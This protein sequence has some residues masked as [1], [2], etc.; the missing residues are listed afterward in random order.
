MIKHT[1]DKQIFVTYKKRSI[2][3]FEFL[4]SKDI[5]EKFGE[6]PF[7]QK[8]EVINVLQFGFT[9]LTNTFRNY[10]LSIDDYAF[11]LFLFYNHESSIALYLRTLGQN[12][13]DLEKAEGIKEDD[14]ALNRRVLRLALEQ[15][16]DINYT[17]DPDVTPAKARECLLKLED[18]LYLGAEIYYFADCIAEN[19]MI[20]NA[21]SLT[22]NQYGRLNIQRNHHNE[23][24]FQAIRGV[25][26]TGF[27]EGIVSVE[28]VNELRTTL[29]KCMAI[30]YDFAGGIIF[31]IKKHHN[32]KDK[33]QTVQPT[34]L[35]QNLAA[36]GVSEVDASNFYSGLSLSRHNKLP[37]ADSVYK[38]NSMERHF[39]RPILILNIKGE[40]RALVGENKWKESIMV[41]A[42]N[43]FQWQ[44][45]PGEWVKNKCFSDYLSEKSNEHDKLLENEVEKV[46]TDLGIPFLR[47]IKKFRNAKNEY[48]PIEIPGVGEMDFVFWDTQRSKLIIADCKYNRARY[49]M[50][51]WS[52]D[53]KNFKE[54]YEPKLQGKLDWIE[55]NMDVVK[56]EFVLR[57]GDIVTN[58]AEPQTFSM[59]IIN[60]PTF[61]MF[62]GSHPAIS[63]NYFKE[64]IKNNYKYPII[65]LIHKSK[66]GQETTT[67]IHH[68]Y[69]MPQ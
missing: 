16:C 4:L 64:F 18:L 43:G 32:T 28:L 38:V 47:N 35:P 30:D 49:E 51:G 1:S 52:T 54:S 42:T 24:V 48:I 58:A 21:Y 7:L 36:K 67:E 13:E 39:F 46:L 5:K 68:P 34:V 12:P 2:D 55:K 27:R 26:H 15:C 57:F 61:Y 41:M 40:E 9:W 69:F 3:K 63:I 50:V 23:E 65:R 22:F 53:F 25:F 29:K 37:I 17:K 60:T 20:D 31:Y 66:E 62:N 19:R 56:N 59:F 45:A 33:A 44:K 14:L 11:L 10:I 8:D 6:D